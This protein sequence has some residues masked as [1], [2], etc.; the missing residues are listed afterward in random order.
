MSSFIRCPKLKSGNL[1]FAIL[2]C[3]LVGL[4]TTAAR[5][6]TRNSRPLVRVDQ[7]DRLLVMRNGSVMKGKIKTISTGYLVSTK[8]GS[9]LITFDQ[10]RFPVDSLADAYLRLRLEVRFPTLPVHRDLANWCIRHKLYREAERELRDA[11]RI[12]PENETVR[13]M[14]DRVQ[15]QIARA[16]PN[17]PVIKKA[18]TFANVGDRPEAR[19][20]SGLSQPTA[21]RFVS[22]IQPLMASHCG[23]ARCHGTASKSD[24]QLTRVRMS[25]GTHRI[26]TE[27]NLASMLKYMDLESPHKSKLLKVTMSSHVGKAMF[28]GRSGNS[29]IQSLKAWVTKVADEMNPD[30]ERTAL[31]SLIRPNSAPNAPRPIQA[32]VG[33]SAAVAT[34]AP[35]STDASPIAAALPPDVALPT[36]T[37]RTKEPTAPVAVSNNPNATP[38]RPVQQSGILRSNFQKLLDEKEPDAF[39]PEAFNRQYSSKR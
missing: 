8:A 2:V 22:V 1:G 31:A 34:R 18:A 13:K 15:Q 23:N 26:A 3:L 19:S 24:F 4:P 20:L 27:R 39:D 6:Q 5:S 21:K 11:L 7:S 28:S 16:A 12:D 32:S 38:T 37:T 25:S 36:E 10:A 29:Q 9:L 35:R 30:R 33:D 17:R 14:L